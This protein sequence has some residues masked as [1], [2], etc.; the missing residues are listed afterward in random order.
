MSAVH[1]SEGVLAPASGALR[2]EP[3]IVA[4]L[5]EVVLRDRTTTP[6]AELAA[7]Y[8]RIRDRIARVLPG[9]SDFNRRVRH[10]G[11]FVLPNGARDR[12]FD[13]PTGRAR[14]SCLPLPD[15]GLE[16]GQLRMTTI[17]S[18]D[19]FNTT[20][21]GLDDRYR[22][23]YGDRNVILVSPS[24]I[25]ARGLRDGGRV[26]VTS[27]FEGRTRRIRGVR[28]VAYDLPPRC[29]AMYFPEANPLVA[30]DNYAEKS[31]TPAY[32]NIVISLAP[33]EVAG[34]EG[35]GD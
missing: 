34:A 12:S 33:S 13:T 28:V 27:H 2:S 22:G 18:H 10:P 23:I 4:G 21:Y 6:W 31:R 8:D 5:A 7:D 20:V 14:F 17:R 9:F 16:P 15:D 32:K 26:D 19:Q 11:G 1:R 30:V 35:A 3:A 25:A 29:A 24:E